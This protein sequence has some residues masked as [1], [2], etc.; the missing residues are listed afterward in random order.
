[1]LNFIC[2]GHVKLQGAWTKW[3]LQ[4]L[5]FLSMVGFEPTPDT[6]PAYETTS[7]N[8]SFKNVDAQCYQAIEQTVAY[9]YMECR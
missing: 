6:A 5:T 3:K 1:M 4:N 2:V 8:A 9:T 7:L